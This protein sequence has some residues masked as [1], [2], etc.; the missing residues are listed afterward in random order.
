M[1]SENSLQFSQQRANDP[2]SDPYESS[3]HPYTLFEIVSD[4][5]FS[6]MPRS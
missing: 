5:I 3:K 6:S 1:E 4:N 2:Y